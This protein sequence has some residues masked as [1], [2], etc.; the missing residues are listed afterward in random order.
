MKC[1]HM[2]FSDAQFLLEA[3]QT[4]GACGPRTDER[5]KAT[6]RKIDWDQQF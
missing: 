3:T 6:A 2:T 4:V 5:R 1:V